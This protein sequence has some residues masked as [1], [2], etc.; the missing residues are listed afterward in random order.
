MGLEDIKNIKSNIDNLEKEKLSKVKEH[1]ETTAELKDLGVAE[2]KKDSSERSKT[3]TETLGPIEDEIRSISKEIDVLRENTDMHKQPK[4][5]LE[6]RMNRL[7]EILRATNT[8]FLNTEEGKEVLEKLKDSNFADKIDLRD[9]AN[10]IT[11]TNL[12]HSASGELEVTKE[13]KEFISRTNRV[14]KLINITHSDLE[15]AKE[16]E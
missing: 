3:F 5:V 14:F 2:K 12:V 6:D 7:T 1:Q 13:L 10:P 8:E 9:E 11:F 15:S 16:G 4:E